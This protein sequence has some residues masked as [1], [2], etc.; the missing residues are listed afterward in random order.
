MLRTKKLMLVAAVTIALSTAAHAQHAMDHKEHATMHGATTMPAEPI[1][2]P[3]EPGQGAFAA[4]A[5]IAR[6]LRDDPDTDWSS[7]DLEALRDHLIDMDA[8]ISDT[9]IETTQVE[10]GLRI[11]IDLIKHQNQAASRMVPAHAPVL[12]EETGWNSAVKTSDGS[13]VWTVT[14]E[15][16][17]AQIKALG[18]YGL[19]AT[20]D[21]HR[22]HH[23]A[24]ASGHSAH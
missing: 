1:G 24:I 8:L 14:G 4:I 19:M 12:A 2:S 16:D 6:I 11:E 22:E 10:S 17:S 13:L 18:F 5:E 20:G 7:V 21:H 15:G 23:L 9:E 3:A